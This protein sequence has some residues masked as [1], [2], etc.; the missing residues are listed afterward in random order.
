MGIDIAVAVD[1]GVIVGSVGV[2]IG[3][4]AEI[5]KP[6]PAMSTRTLCSL[7]NLCPRRRSLP[8]K[9]TSKTNSVIMTISGSTPRKLP[10]ETLAR[11]QRLFKTNARDF[12][13]HRI[14]FMVFVMAILNNTHYLLC[15]RK[16]QNLKAILESHYVCIFV[17][18][19]K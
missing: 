5:P 18:C 17:N 13:N 19:I 15:A 6:K 3:L 12:T 10:K 7:D 2:R 8:D 9:P 4:Q 11:F 16:G 1:V 14:D